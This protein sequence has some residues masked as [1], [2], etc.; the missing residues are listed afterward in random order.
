MHTQFYLSSCVHVSVLSS[1]H[2]L[3]HGPGRDDIG[4][5]TAKAVRPRRVQS[6]G[7]KKVARAALLNPQCLRVGEQ[8][9]QRRHERIDQQ[10]PCPAQR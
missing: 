10:P 7:R 4:G 5:A 9:F 3:E 2:V 1:V 6:A 8:R